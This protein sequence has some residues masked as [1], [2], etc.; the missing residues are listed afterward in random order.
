M[1]RRIWIDAENTT[2]ALCLGLFALAG[3]SSLPAQESLV[4]A[5]RLV[6][7]GATLIDGA[8]GTPLRDAVVVIEGN[9]IAAVGPAG[10]ISV[11]PGAEVI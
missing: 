7:Q 11:P 2:R 8:G 1:L 4:G 5:N 6:I 10:Q 3:I 9:R